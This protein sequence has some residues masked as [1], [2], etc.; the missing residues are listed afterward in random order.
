MRPRFETGRWRMPPSR[1]VEVVTAEL[2]RIAIGECGPE[3]PA[4]RHAQM[5]GFRRAKT[6]L[7][8]V[9][10]VTYADNPHHRIRPWN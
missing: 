10:F 7:V 9:G 3:N 1:V 6:L 8:S 5:A 2:R 4:T